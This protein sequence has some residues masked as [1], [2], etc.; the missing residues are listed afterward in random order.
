VQSR[1]ITATVLVALSLAGCSDYGPTSQADC[2]EIDSQDEPL[3]YYDTSGEGGEC[4]TRDDIEEA[5]DESQEN[6]E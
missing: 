3:Y 1:R 2:D 4:F 5:L 6:S